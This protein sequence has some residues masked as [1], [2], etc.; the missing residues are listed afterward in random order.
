MAKKG[1]SSCFVPIPNTIVH[2]FLLCT[3]VHHLVLFQHEFFAFIHGVAALP[4]L[5][6]HWLTPCW[7]INSFLSEISVCC[8]C[9]EKITIKIERA[10]SVIL[11]ALPATCRSFQQTPQLPTV[12]VANL[13][14]NKQ[15]VTANARWCLPSP[16]LVDCIVNSSA[17]CWHKHLLI[18][19]ALAGRLGANVYQ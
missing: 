12:A 8:S 17:V 13:R 10:F 15:L 19:V 9:T 1:I 6:C 7:K 5:M 14:F 18:E 2:N 11:Q 3:K 4:C 16:A